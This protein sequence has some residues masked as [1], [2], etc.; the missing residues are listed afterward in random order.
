MNAD[1]FLASEFTPADPES[2][3]FHVIPA[4]LERTVSYGGGTAGAPEAILAASQQLEAFD[5]VS[6]PGELGIHTTAPIDATGST[7]AVLDEI[8][9]HI[10]QALTTGSVP[11]LLGGEHTVTLGALRALTG[12]HEPVGIVQFDAHADLRPSYQGSP[13]SHACVMHHAFSLGFPLMQIGV[14]SLSP[15]EVTLRKKNPG[16][17]RHA[18]ARQFHCNGIDACQLPKDFPR[19]IY[20]TFDVDGLDPSLMPATGTPEPGGL[21]WHEA[22]DAIECVLKG[23]Q[24]IGFDVVELAPTPGLH[25]PDLTAARLVYNLMGYATRTMPPAQ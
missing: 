15:E 5:G 22:M 10:H 7:E 13:L 17:I 4:G 1:P 11:A 2:A 24:L 25:H 19:K 20:I 23:R 12:H 14:R 6:C 3:R 18:D 16:A 21:F 8:E 9:H